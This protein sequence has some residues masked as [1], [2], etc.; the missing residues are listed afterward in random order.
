MFRKTNGDP[1]LCRRETS[2]DSGVKTSGLFRKTNGDRPSGG[3]DCG[4]SVMDG[5]GA[6]VRKTNAQ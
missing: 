3:W 4:L 2:Q 6:D 1:G 5:R